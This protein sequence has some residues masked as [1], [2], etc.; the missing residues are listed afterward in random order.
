MRRVMTGLRNGGQPKLARQV[1]EVGVGD[2]IVGP[3]RRRPQRGI[4]VEIDQLIAVPAVDVVDRGGHLLGQL[5][6]V[7]DRGLMNVGHC[8]IGIVDE[9]VAGIAAPASR[10]ERAY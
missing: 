4:Q 2:A 10:L 8:S 5:S 9:D 6:F 3:A 7:A 1:I